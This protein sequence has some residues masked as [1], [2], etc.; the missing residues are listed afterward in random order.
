M[1]LLNKII[2]FF[3]NEKDKGVILLKQKPR[4]KYIVKNNNI[5]KRCNIQ[6]G[7]Y[8]GQGD[9]PRRSWVYIRK[10]YCPKYY[11]ELNINVN[12][13][14]CNNEKI[15]SCWGDTNECS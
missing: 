11:R 15:R 14:G 12:K 10:D 3:K 1:D 13:K 8:Y 5:Y 9:K 2:N 6:T 7:S 4:L